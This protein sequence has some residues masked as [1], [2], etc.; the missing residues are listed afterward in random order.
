MRNWFQAWVRPS[1]NLVDTILIFA[2]DHDLDELPY[3]E[4]L[5]WYGK[6]SLIFLYKLFNGV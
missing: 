2:I 1:T 3:N 6:G 4:S 5:V